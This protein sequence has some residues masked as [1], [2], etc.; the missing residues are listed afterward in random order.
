[1]PV[2]LFGA[3][4][5]RIQQELGFGTRELGFAVSAYFAAGG[6]AAPRIGVLID[7]I[8]TRKALRLGMLCSLVASVVVAWLAD[9]WW[10]GALGMA[11]CGLAHAFTQLGL[12]RMLVQGGSATNGALGFG[13]KQ[14]AVPM[15][16]LLAGFATAALV[17]GAPWRSLYAG[18]AAVAVLLGA[19]VP[20]SQTNQTLPLVPRVSKPGSR[21]K[22]LALAASF[23]AGA[24]NSVSL[25]IVDAFDASG[26]SDNAGA[27]ILGLGSGLAAAS[28]LGGGWVVGRRRSDGALEL[29][30]LMAVGAMG[31]VLLAISGGSVI[32]LS[33]GALIAFLA[34]WGWQGIVFYAATRDVG[35]PPAT[36]SGI[37]LSGTMS[38]SV[39]GPLAISA[40]ADAAGY[41]L[42]W[43]VASL[44]LVAGAL[45]VP[46][47]G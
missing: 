10:V 45:T 14:A 21:L 34:G 25:L 27:L 18:A 9:S 22:R 1:M 37:V 38:G 7:R 41:G 5:V 30:L 3:N 43:G 42:A 20:S 24:G 29:R 44:A 31:F 26:F 19:L 33:L 47:R 11:S 6:L 35:I 2:F 32:V 39:V 36:S 46:R 13:I 8:G 12:N 16:S 15:A 23:A 28:R 4:A 17:P 40:I